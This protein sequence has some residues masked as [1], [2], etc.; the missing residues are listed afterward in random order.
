[1]VVVVEMEVGERGKL[2][3]V[4]VV[5]EVGDRGVVGVKARR[6]GKGAAKG[7]TRNVRWAG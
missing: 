7:L 2:V 1:M 3:V 5:V 6:E 4:V